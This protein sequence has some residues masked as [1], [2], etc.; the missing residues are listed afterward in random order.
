[1]SLIIQNL[2]QQKRRKSIGLD[3]IAI[4]RVAITNKILHTRGLFLLLNI[5]SRFYFL[6][7]YY[8]D[9]Y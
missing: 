3:P 9:E 4:I 1:M 6:L 8:S 7:L 2:L 5:H